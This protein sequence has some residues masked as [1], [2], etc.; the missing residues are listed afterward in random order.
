MTAI[1]YD[2]I[3]KR[4]LDFMGSTMHFVGQGYKIYLGLYQEM[5][6]GHYNE[7]VFFSRIPR[8]MTTGLFE[9]IKKL[10]PDEPR[11][12]L[13]PTVALEDGQQHYV[14]RLTENRFSPLT[15]EQER[16]RHEHPVGLLSATVI[17]GESQ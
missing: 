4:F 15:E 11:F 9:A 1:N 3:A 2:A 12:T 6:P 17:A 7:I 16:Y 5:Y 14:L 8:P 10:R 13:D